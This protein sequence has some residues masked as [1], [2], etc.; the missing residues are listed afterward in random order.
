MGALF[1]GYAVTDIGVPDLQHGR[2]FRADHDDPSLFRPSLGQE[3]RSA[4]VRVGCV[5][6][7]WLLGPESVTASLTPDP[8]A[9]VN[10]LDPQAGRA[11]GAEGDDVRWDVIQRRS[12]RVPQDRRST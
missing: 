5:Q 6:F 12:S 10:V 9:L 7:V 8:L 2:T 4:P 1:T 11:V 3:E